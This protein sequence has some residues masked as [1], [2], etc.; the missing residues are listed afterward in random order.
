[1]SADPEQ[2]NRRLAGA[3]GNSNWVMAGV[4]KGGVLRALVDGAR[5]LVK[6]CRDY[7]LEQS[8]Y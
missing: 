3:A 4:P 7:D 1:L 6:L 2:A 8:K 5:K